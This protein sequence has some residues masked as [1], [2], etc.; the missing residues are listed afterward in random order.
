M[1]FQAQV[2]TVDSFFL[3]DSTVINLKWHFT[4]FY[5]RVMLKPLRWDHQILDSICGQK[6]LKIVEKF[7][8]FSKITLFIYLKEKFYKSIDRYKSCEYLQTFLYSCFVYYY[9]KLFMLIHF[10]FVRL[11]FYRMPGEARHPL[12]Q[13]GMADSCG[14]DSFI[15]LQAP[16]SA[17]LQIA[18]S[19]WLMWLLG[20]KQ[21]IFWHLFN[22]Q[23]NSETNAQFVW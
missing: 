23:E 6:K 11:K 12:G 17:H 3:R 10:Y 8:K 20:P 7:V 22:F 9:V 5:I 19:E 15:Q 4:W 16:S 18:P 13:F 1:F 21:E 2:I 14:L